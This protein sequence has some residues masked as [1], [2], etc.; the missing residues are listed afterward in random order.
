MVVYY[1]PM[2]KTKHTP[3]RNLR[4]RPSFLLSQLG[5]HSDKRFNE[6]LEPI[7][8]NARQFGLLRILA[9]ATWQSQQQLSEALRIHRNVMVGMVDE[10]D[11]RRLVERRRDPA[12]RRAHAVHLTDTARQILPRGES[13]L[14][15]C[16]DELLG[17]LDAVERK[18]LVTLL[19]RVA[20]DAGLIPGVHPGYDAIEP[21]R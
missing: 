12:D 21:A 7:G 19:Q 20:D 15:A 3:A 9:H 10:L 18:T 2:V 11:R 1:Q 4:E 13:I 8:I 5:F 14:D 6:L 17:S 16:D